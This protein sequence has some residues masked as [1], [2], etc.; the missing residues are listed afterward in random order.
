MSTATAPR[1]AAQTKTVEHDDGALLNEVLERTATKLDA[2]ASRYAAA[3][4]DE[5]IGRLKRS[6][7]TAQGVEALK[8]ILTGEIMDLFMPLM[9]TEIGFDTDRNPAKPSKKN[10]DQKPVPY[11]V[12][13][14]RDCLIVAF[15]RKVYPFNNEFNIIA[16]KVYVTKSGYQRKVKELPGLT[17][18]K[19]AI[20]PPQVHAGMT[21]CRATATW[22]YNGVADELPAMADRPGMLFPIN[23]SEGLG[24]D[25]ILGKAT[26]HVLKAVF[27]QITGSEISADETGLQSEAA[28]VKGPRDD[29]LADRLA[30]KAN[31]TPK[32]KDG[33]PFV[34]KEQA[35][36]IAEEDAKPAAKLGD[37]P[38]YFTIHEALEAA[39]ISGPKCAAAFGAAKLKELP[40]SKAKEV[41][42]WIAANK[43]GDAAE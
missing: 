40:V 12:T 17:D 32:P 37:T 33:E 7:I 5:T 18:L 36:A 8:K 2:V 29:S 25:A 34:T 1:T 13:S 31:G 11:P 27:E 19:Y 30:A 43:V 24:N 23:T 3:I 20:Q 38:E 9:N 6:I 10:P 4:E 26:R 42:E 15:L 41:M 16:G 28:P 21:C 22:K 14:V 35:S 39:N